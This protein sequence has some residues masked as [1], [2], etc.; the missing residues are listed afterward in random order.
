MGDARNP[1]RGRGAVFNPANR[2]EALRVEEDPDC[3]IA[4]EDRPKL[5]TQ[6]FSD[7]T[8]SLIVYNKSPDVGFTAGINVYRGCE[9]GCAYCY[10][11]PSHEYLG[12]N[13]GLDFESRIMV[14]RR[15]PEL[16]RRE[17]MKP[18][19][20]P[21]VLTMSGNTDCYQP[22]ERKLRLTRCCLEVLA[23]FRNPVAIITKNYLVTRDVD[24]LAELAKY[25]CAMVYVSIN[26]LDADLAAKL[27]PRAASPKHRL[28]AVRKLS[29][30]GVPVGVMNAP[31]IPGL[32]DHEIPQVLKAAADAGARS[33]GRTVVRLPYAVK[34]LFAA[35]LETHYPD[36]KQ[37]VLDRIRSM[38][39]GKLNVSE[40]GAR[41]RGTGFFA[42]QISQL[43]RVSVRR[44]GL[45][46][47][48]TELSTDAFRR[49]GE[50]IQ[51]PLL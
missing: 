15:A 23:D 1:E 38:R 19:W 46:K 29:E 2:F 37:R 21:Q 41:M 3:E 12:F 24:L 13:S 18:G 39:D 40:F 34:D 8:Q 35:W 36:R 47:D 9:H 43:F 11:R 30:A 26:S 50:I 45:D 7:D 22:V 31:V 44:A 51:M 27:E 49:P 6:F 42:E 4:E 10:A 14:K 17:L 5:R 33:A 28:E 48:D 25:Q 32:N 16:L 20:K